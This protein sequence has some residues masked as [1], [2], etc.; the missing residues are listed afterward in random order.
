[1]LYSTVEI[2]VFWHSYECAFKKAGY[3]SAHAYFDV[4]PA[5]ALKVCTCAQKEIIS[6]FIL[7]AHPHMFAG[8]YIKKEMSI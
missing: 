5:R 6:Q 8:S 1:M 2:I 3:L 4:A 7:D